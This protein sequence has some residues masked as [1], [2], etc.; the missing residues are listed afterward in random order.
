MGLAALDLSYVAC[1]RFS[2]HY[3]SMLNPWDVAAGILIVREAGGK[4]S[5]YNGD[6]KGY[7]GKETMAAAPQFYNIVKK[8]LNR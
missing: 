5:Y 6:E 7:S 2:T 8:V 1:G 3:E 4:V